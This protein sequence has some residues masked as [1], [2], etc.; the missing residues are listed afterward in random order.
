MKT[1]YKKTTLP[2]VIIIIMLMTNHFASHAQTWQWAASMGNNSADPNPAPDEMVRDMEVD[3][4][5]N[6]YVCGEIRPNGLIGGQPATTYGMLHTG[7]VA[8]YDCNGT[9]V[10][11]HTFGNINR[12]YAT[13]IELDGNGHLYLT[14]Q[15]HSSTFPNYEL[16]FMDTVITDTIFDLFLAKLDTSGNRIWLNIAGPGGAQ[17]N[18]RPYTM[19]IDPHGKINILIFAN[20]GELYNGLNIQTGNYTIKYDTTGNVI[21][22]RYLSPELY[23]YTIVNYDIEYDSFGNWYMATFFFQDTITIG[24]QQIIRN[25]NLAGG[26]QFDLLFIKL[27]SMN[28][29]QWYIQIGDSSLSA[30]GWGVELDGPNHVVFTGRARAGI[31]LQG[32][33]FTN[34]LGNSPLTNV[35]FI[36]KFDTAGNL[37]WADNVHSQYS[38][39]GGGKLAR[40][41]TGNFYFSGIYIGNAIFGTTN[42]TSVNQV[43]FYLCKVNPSG[44]IQS[45][46]TFATTGT[47]PYATETRTDASGNVYVAGSFDGTITINGVTQVNQGGNSNGFVAKYG[48]QCSTGL[49]DENSLA[50]QMSLQLYPNPA[51]DVVNVSGFTAG[52]TIR[53]LLTDITGRA[54]AGNASQAIREDYFQ[55]ETAH[56]SPGMYLI[57]IYDQTGRKSAR[58]MKN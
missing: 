22:V 6:V 12:S 2:L 8:K 35:T 23:N 45:A 50:Y 24:G 52:K 11:A 39:S 57:T 26:S 48:Y 13:A 10:W 53:W 47:K 4:Q 29:T 1:I 58:L 42:M 20:S 40:D 15:V 38:C 46:T 19:D 30:A 43:D 28:K 3:D 36:A 41:S 7:F 31:N 16:Y 49:E 25:V 5:G 21:N 55:I 27:D 44:T 17:L 37:V 32:H 56:L 34:P 54:V 51:N 14:G 18:S 33:I 9:L